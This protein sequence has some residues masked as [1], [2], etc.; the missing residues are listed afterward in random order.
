MRCCFSCDKSEFFRPSCSTLLISND[1]QCLNFYCLNCY[2][3]QACNYAIEIARSDYLIL[4]PSLVSC[5]AMNEEVVLK[6]LFCCTVSGRVRVA[7][8]LRPRNDEEL[9]ADADFADCVELQ[10]EVCEV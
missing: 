5:P 1:N 2:S 8:R 9:E 3:Q 4:A 6:F 7:V 10:P